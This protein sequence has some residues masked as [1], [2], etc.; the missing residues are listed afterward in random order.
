MPQHDH[1]D[2]A[3]L[4]NTNDKKSLH[5]QRQSHL[6]FGLKKYIYIIYMYIIPRLY[7]Q[8]EVENF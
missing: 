2:G 1:L 4:E 3:L 6:K 8:I 5:D 7:T